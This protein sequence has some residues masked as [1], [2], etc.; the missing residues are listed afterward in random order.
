MSFNLLGANELT[1]LHEILTSKSVDNHVPADD[2]AS[3]T[4]PTIADT[5]MMT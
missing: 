4:S 5:V 2:L 3:V 1:L